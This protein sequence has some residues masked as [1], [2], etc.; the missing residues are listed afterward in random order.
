MNPII[1]PNT[2]TEEQREKLKYIY[3]GDALNLEDAELGYKWLLQGAMNRMKLIFGENFLR[4]ENDMAWLACDKDGEEYIFRSEPYRFY[5]ELWEDGKRAI[6]LP[7][8]SIAKLIGRE[9]TWCDE[10][11]KLE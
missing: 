8:G 7:K 9:L 5:N 11:V 10:P 1:D 4:K 2:L 3:E 6:K